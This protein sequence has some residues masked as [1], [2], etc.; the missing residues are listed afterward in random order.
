MNRIQSNFQSVYKDFFAENDLIL[1]WCFS[2]KWWLWWISHGSKP[3]II[4][5]KMPLK[6]YIWFKLREDDNINFK[7][8]QYYD[9][10]SKCFQKCDYSDVNQ[11][12]ENIKNLIKIYVDI[13]NHFLSLDMKRVDILC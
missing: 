9:V 5:Q 8:F 1:S 11:E 3:F 6:S 4:R 13:R 10:V 2:F 12:Q 7:S